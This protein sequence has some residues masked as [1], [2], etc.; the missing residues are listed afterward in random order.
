MPDE[1]KPQRDEPRA[2]QSGDPRPWTGPL[3]QAVPLSFAVCVNDEAVLAANLM[4]SPCLGPGTAP[5]HRPPQP[6]QR[7][8]GAERRPGAGE[9]RVGRLRAPGCGPAA[10]LGP[11]N[12]RTIPAGRATI[13]VDRRG[14][15][16]RRRPGDR[17]PVIP[18]SARGA[19]GRPG[20]GSGSPA[21]PW[22]GSARAGRHAGR[23]VAHH[24]AGFAAPVRRGPGVPPLWGRSLPPG[25]GARTGGRGSSRPRVGTIPGNIGLTESFVRSARIFA[26]K[27]GR[28]VAGGDAIH[29]VRPRGRVFVLGNAEAG[30]GSLARPEWGRP[31]RTDRA[32]LGEG[33]GDITNS[34]DRV[35]GGTP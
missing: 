3:Q 13:G 6:A 12:P 7:R 15:G 20:R 5:G 29:T 1:D 21:A 23:A 30:S 10:E 34:S 22:A 8:R 27:M 18:G 11:A 2:A 33:V 17:S 32:S 26:R 28:S 19:A 31:S 25:R 24:S 9:A 16:L 4:T 35:A 14:R